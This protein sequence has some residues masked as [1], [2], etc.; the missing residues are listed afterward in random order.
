MADDLLEDGG[1]FTGLKGRPAREQVVQNSPKAEQVAAPVKFFSTQLL[2][3]H[4]LGSSEY[5]ALPRETTGGKL[6]DS[7]I[8]NLGNAA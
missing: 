4:E 2:R 7:E 6:G 8:G 1:D 5:D 3:R